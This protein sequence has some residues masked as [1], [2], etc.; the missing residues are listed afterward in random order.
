VI[1]KEVFQAK[2]ILISTISEQIKLTS[3]NWLRAKVTGFKYSI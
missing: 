3:R 2:N 1:S